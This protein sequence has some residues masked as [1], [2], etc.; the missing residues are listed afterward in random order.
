MMNHITLCVSVVVCP[1]SKFYDIII[2][3]IL[4]VR[5]VVCPDAKCYGIIIH[6]TLCVNFIGVS[7]WQCVMSQKNMIGIFI[8]Y[9]VSVCHFY[10]CVL[11]AVCHASKGYGIIIHILLFNV[12]IIL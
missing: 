3:I 5:V 9:C 10:W 7:V 2:H 11:M 8:L 1:V 12:I 6:I 4:R